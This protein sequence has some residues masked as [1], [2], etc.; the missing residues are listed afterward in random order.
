MIFCLSKTHQKKH[1][2]VVPIFSPSKLYRKIISKRRRLFAHQNYIKK[3]RQYDVEICR[4]WRVSV[5]LIL[6]R[7]VES[8]GITQEQNVFSVNPKST[9]FQR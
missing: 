5:I 7:R 6:V 4:N 8:V 1:I 3:A 9:L 2:E